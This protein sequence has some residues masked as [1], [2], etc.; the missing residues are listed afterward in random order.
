M[1]IFFV[2]RGFPS[3][4]NL[5][6]GNYESVQARALAKMGH[7]VINICKPAYKSEL[8]LFDR[9][10]LT[11]RTVDGVKVYEKIAFKGVKETCLG[12]GIPN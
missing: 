8:H 9:P 6:M 12:K 7:E 3:E 2:T 10:R 4:K 11:C 5:M 1:K